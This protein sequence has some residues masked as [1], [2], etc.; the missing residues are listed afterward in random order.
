MK[1]IFGSVSLLFLLVMTMACTQGTPPLPGPAASTPRMAATAPPALPTAMPVSPTTGAA[2][3]SPTLAPVATSP[4]VQVPSGA[5]AVVNGQAISMAEYQKQIARA[6]SFFIDQGLVDPNTDE[7]KE[8]LEQINR[9]VLEDELI[10]QVIMSQAATKLGVVVSDVEV[11]ASVDS[12][13][14]E[15]GGKSAFEQGLVQRGLTFDEFVQEQ[16]DQ[17]LANALRD[18]VTADISRKAEQIHARHILVDKAEEAQK[19]LARLKAGEDFAKIAKEVSLDIGSAENGGD[20]GWFPRG[21]MVPEFEE[22]AFKLQKGQVSDVV[23]S[24]FGYHIIQLIEKEASRELD[25]DLW[26]NLRQQKFIDWLDEQR[27]RANIQILIG[28]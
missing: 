13:I 17:L 5:A 18:K 19:V 12:V 3:T 16:R 4:A 10:S 22:V 28:K 27:A 26:Q 14:K 2:K 25:E 24:P 23:K 9:Q 21:S 6:R 20:L 7:G 1:R 11:Q 8:R 15:L